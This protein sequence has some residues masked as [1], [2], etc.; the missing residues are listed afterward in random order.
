MGFAKSLNAI[1]AHLPNSRQ[2]LLFS[3]TQTTSVKDLARLSLKDPAYVGVNEADI[4]GA[5]PS[6]LEQHYI[7]VELDRKLDV[8]YSF[9]RTH[10]TS[11]ML[12]FLSCCKQVSFNSIQC[13]HT[14]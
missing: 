3:A 6:N 13:L 12:V 1:V 14:D 4:E 8:L 11:K 5:M 7:V 9:I 10:L 2:T